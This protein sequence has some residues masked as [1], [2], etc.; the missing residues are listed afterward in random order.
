MADAAILVHFVE[1]YQQVGIFL[2]EAQCRI[3]DPLSAA[4]DGFVAET[5]AAHHGGLRHYLVVERQL[6]FVMTE[7][8][9]ETGLPSFMEQLRGTRCMVITREN[10]GIHWRD[11]THDG[12]DDGKA[13]RF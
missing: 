2:R 3:D 12:L 7:Y 5:T 11:I 8:D 4:L 13:T 10:Q 1:T 9:G 6:R